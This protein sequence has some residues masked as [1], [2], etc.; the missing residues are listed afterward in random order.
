[1]HNGRR[2]RVHIFYR[3][4]LQISEI[5]SIFD[6]DLDTAVAKVRVHVTNLGLRTANF[7]IDASDRDSPQENRRKSVVHPQHTAVISLP[8]KCNVD[9]CGAIGE[10]V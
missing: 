6:D 10:M 5:H 1:M 8:I 4:S 3:I 2:T 7:F 9:E